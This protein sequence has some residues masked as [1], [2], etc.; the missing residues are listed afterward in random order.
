MRLDR[1][2]P[3]SW[4]KQGLIYQPDVSEFTHGSHPSIVYYNDNIFVLAFAR[5][6]AQQRSHIFLC[7]AEVRD[8]ALKLIS[9][10]K[11]AMKYGEPGHYDCHGVIGSCFVQHNANFYL[12]YVGWLNL[13]DK[14]WVYS[15]GRA[16]LDPDNLTLEREFRGPV[17]GANKENPMFASIVA[18]HITESNLWQAWYNAGVRW[19]REGD[20]WK[21]YYGL[22]Y[23]HSQNGVDWICDSEMCIPFADEYEYA[24]GRPSVIVKNGTYYM[25]YAHRATKYITTYRFGFATSKDGRR[26]NRKDALVGIDVSPEGW[27]SEMLC[28]PCVFEHKNTLYMLYN[29]NG[30]GKTGFGL[31]VL[32]DD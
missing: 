1:V 15:T 31:A 14:M 23:G 17:L 24:F 8:G 10:P 9:E 6:D 30:Y 19:E 21:P 7:H 27:D 26:W 5:R 20:G 11:M 12:Y 18:C 22:H 2:T 16:V 25:W 29:G 4:K 28:Y 3:F 13:P 32:E